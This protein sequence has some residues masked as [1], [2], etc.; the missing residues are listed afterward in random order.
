[1]IT[2][3]KINFNFVNFI[4]KLEKYNI[5]P[6]SIKNDSEFNNLLR[7]ASAFTSEDSGGAYAG[8]LIEHITRIAMIA[9]NVNKMLQ[10]EVKVNLDSLIKV[11]YLHQISKAIMISKNDVDWEIKKGKIFKFNKNL[12]AIK[13]A[14]YSLFLC[15]KY[16]IELTEEE[17]EAISSTD[18]MDD[19]QTKYFSNML[20]QILRTSIE[21]AN[22][23]R[24]LRYKHYKGE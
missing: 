24:R 19:E 10:D 22:S 13:T 15:L 23:E 17:F 7:D 11:C 2:E 4:A 6:E 9:F 3:E 20:S 18:K 5:Y 8:S 21:L 12:P 1:M 16:G 14:E